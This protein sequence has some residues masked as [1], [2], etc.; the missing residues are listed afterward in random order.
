MIFMSG[1][2]RGCSTLF[3]SSGH[4]H[5]I[6]AI[7]AFSTKRALRPR[8]YRAVSNVPSRL[9]DKPSRDKFSSAGV[10]VAVRLYPIKHFS[11]VNRVAVLAANEGR[12]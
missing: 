11:F 2:A 10:L 4:V 5:S 3:D 6:T 9:C 7:Q 1:K 8:R 12:P